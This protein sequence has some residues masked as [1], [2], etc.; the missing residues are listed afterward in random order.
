MF[1]ILSFYFL[2]VLIEGST[3]FSLNQNQFVL[4]KE[5]LLQ[6][7]VAN[8]QKENVMLRNG[9]AKVEECDLES[10]VTEMMKILEA[11]GQVSN[12]HTV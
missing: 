11:H 9:L 2:L 6:D 4:S 12:S 5:T 3:V 10:N 8:L 1:P 7:A